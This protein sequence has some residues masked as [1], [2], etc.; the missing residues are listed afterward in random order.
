MFWN[1]LIESQNKIKIFGKNSGVGFKSDYI[2]ACGYKKHILKN[3][4][5]FFSVVKIYIT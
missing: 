2:N 3:F 4:K 1:I 5:Q